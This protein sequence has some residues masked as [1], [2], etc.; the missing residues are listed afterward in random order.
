LL[1]LLS[2]VVLTQDLLPLMQCWVPAVHP[3]A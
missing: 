2:L 3:Q 1:L